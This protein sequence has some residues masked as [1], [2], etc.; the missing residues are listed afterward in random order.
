MKQPL[1]IP[2]LIAEILM[3]IALSEAIVVLL[4][5]VVTPRM[6]GTL[7]VV[8]DSAMLSILAGPAI[9]W[10]L[11]AAV[12]RSST[13][14]DNAKEGRPWRL[15]ATTVGVLAFGLTA[16]G[17]A[18]VTTCRG[19]THDAHARFELLTERM[20][21]DIERRLMQ[22]MYGLAGAR[23]MYAANTT[24]GREEFRAYVASRDLPREF[25]GTIGMGFIQRVRRADLDAFVAAEHADGVPD[26]AVRSLATPGSALGAAPDL[27]VVKHCFPKERNAAAW[28]LDLGS[29]PVCR[30]AIERAVRTGEPTISGK[31]RLVQD[32]EERI[33]HLFFLPVYR[34]GTTPATPGEREASLVGV[35]YAPMILEEAFAGLADAFLGEMDFEI[36]DGEQPHATTRIFDLDGHTEGVSGTIDAFAFSGRMFHRTIPVTMVGRPWTITTSTTPVFEGRFDRTTPALLGAGGAVLSLMSAAF[37]WTLGSGRVRALRLAES[38][39]TELTAALHETEALRSTIEAHT[40]ISETD[41]SGRITYANDLFCKISKYTREELIGK[42]HSILNSGHHPKAFWV[43]MWR[44]IASG[45]VW[46]GEVCNRAKDGSLYWVDSI[47][48]P[49]RGKSGRIEKYVSIRTD[50]TARKQAEADLIDAVNDIR[51]LAAAVDSHADCVFLADMSGRI[52][53]VNPAFERITGYSAKEAIGQPFDMLRGGQTPDDVYEALW[54]TIRAGKPWSGRLCNRRPRRSSRAGDLQLPILGQGCSTP[55]SFDEY[56]VDASITPVRDNEGRVTGYVAIER[57]VTPIVLAEEVERQRAEAV[58]ARYAVAK[59][60]NGMGDLATRLGDAVEIVF[61]MRNMEV[62]KKGGVFLLEEGD[63]H[64]RMYVWRGQFSQEFLRDEAVVPLGRCLCGRAAVSGEVIVSDNCFTDHRHENHWPNMK[65]HGHYIV[66][67]MDRSTHQRP[68][69]VGVMFLYTDVNPI[70]TTERL[71]GLREIG[72]L[73]ALAILKDRAARMQEMARAAAERANRAKSTFLANMSHE[74]RT[75]LTAILGYADLL[76]EEG[77]AS[78]APEQRAQMIDT[79][80]SAGQHL[81]TVIND[82]LDLSRIEADKIIIERIETP[83]TDMLGEIESLMRARAVAKGITLTTRLASPV[84]DRIMSD[85][86]RLRQILMNLVGNAVKFTESGGVTVTADVADLDG[87]PRLVIDVEDTGIGMTREQAERLFNAFSQADETTTRKYGGTGLGLV[88]CRRLANLMGGDVKLQR[89]EP[90]KGSCFRVVLPLEPAPGSAMVTRLDEKTAPRAAAAPQAMVTLRGRILLV[91]DGVDNQRLIS[92]HLRKAGAEVAVADNG[93]IALDM[94]DRAQ[95]EGRPF[96]LLLTD[97]QMPE[98]DGYTLARTLRDR[99]NTLPIIALTA[100]AMAEDREKCLAAGC[101]DFATKPIDRS[102]LLAMCAAW[103]GRTGGA[104]ARSKAA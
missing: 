98:I 31:T 16:T 88:I 24:V 83:L 65:P 64:L 101:N 45:R 51:E 20:V 74:I 37:V 82:I 75:P 95:A 13:A 52:T 32:N 85:P 89:T 93:K 2:R 17:F 63:M 29:E 4:L 66:P 19:I 11:L 61:N 68:V 94:I 70:A 86:T 34:N 78:P 49:F 33:G 99:G 42:R 92:F 58:E 22:V 12:K 28:G 39:S 102:A 73:M 41:L 14:P 7:E 6:A 53:R 60:L 27:Y 55:A 97:M 54:S 59:V 10:R 87:R 9:I 50:I 3:V 36:F 44:T 100:H 21:G 71:D 26:F 103:M 77:N 79:I 57:D 96:D 18:V 25:P 35:L 69:C 62:Q 5:P 104:F 30:E 8:L 91:E 46:H 81:L 47:I 76:R 43:E 23:W 1:N 67:L 72:D 84:P 15:T 90:G 48:A 40:I 80:R 38:M 56:W